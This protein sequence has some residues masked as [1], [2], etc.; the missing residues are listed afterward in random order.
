MTFDE[1][2][3]MTVLQLRKLAKDH[4]VVLGAGID[5]AGIIDKLLPVLSGDEASGSGSEEAEHL[6]EPKFQAAWHN[7][8]APRYSA[9]PAYQAPGSAPRP[10]WQNTT[11]SG[12]HLTHE[13]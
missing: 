9:R 12:Q 4:S 5:K 8:D 3:E 2:N 1:L 7:A 6:A 13:Q 10:A 11:P